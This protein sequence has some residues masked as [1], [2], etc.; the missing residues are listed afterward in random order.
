MPPTGVNAKVKDPEYCNWLKVGLALYYLKDG[1]GS[2]IQDE[3]DAM[4]QSLLQKLYNASTVPAQLCSSCNAKDVKQNRKTYAWE[5]K[6]RCPISL[7]DT[8]LTELLALCTNPTSSKLYCENCAVTAWPKSPWECA[9]FYMPRG[10]AVHN[11]GPAQSDSQALLTLMASCKHF[12]SKL[13]PGGIQLT[14]TVS[15]IRNTVMHSGDMRLSDN[16]RTRYITDIIK[17]LEDPSHLKSL[18][19]CKKAVAEINK[20]NTDS[21]E[22]FFNTD[23][24]L[25]MMALRACAEGCRQELGV[26]RV[27]TEKTVESLKEE[28]KNL[29][30]KIKDKVGDIDT[31]C[32]K[33]GARV[34]KLTSGLKNVKGQ[35]RTQSAMVKKTDKLLKR[36][37]L[38]GLCQQKKKV[39][40]LEKEVKFIQERDSL[41]SA[42]TASQVSLMN[43]ESDVRDIQ[44]LLL[45]AYKGVQIISVNAVL[46]NAVYWKDIEDFYTDI[47]IEQEAE[48]ESTQRK[49]NEQQLKKTVTSFKQIFKKCDSNMTRIVL[50]APAGQGKSTFCRKLVHTWCSVQKKRLN[51]P[52]DDG[53]SDWSETTGLKHED[54]ML[55]FDVLLYICLRDISDEETLMDVVY[56]QFPLD[57][58]E[59][60]VSH[61]ETLIGQAENNKVLL[62][63]DGLDEM[64]NSVSFIGQILQRKLY[65]SLTVLATTR[66]WKI[67]ELKLIRSAHI[68][69]FLDL[70]GF[71][72]DNSMLFAKKMFDNYYKDESAMAQFE[73]DILKNDVIRSLIHVPLLL[74]F[75]VQVWYDRKSFPQTIQELY[76]QMFD[77]IVNR[78]IEVNERIGK[79]QG[80]Q[81]QKIQFLP[82]GYPKES[83]TFNAN[84]KLSKLSILKHFGADF[85]AALCEVANHFLIKACGESA[86]V[87]DEEVLLELLG[88]EGTS[89]LQTAL[90]LGILAKSESRGTF[91]KKICLTFLHKTVQEFLA[92][93]SICCRENTCNIFLGSLHTVSDVLQNEQIIKFAAGISTSQCQKIFETIYEVCDKHILEEYK[94]HDLSRLYIDCIKEARNE[95]LTLKFY[96]LYVKCENIW[97]ELLSALKNT[98]TT[99]IH[100]SYLYLQSCIL[101][102]AELDFFEFQCLTIIHLKSTTVKGKLLLSKCT[103]LKCLDLKNCTFDDDV[104]DLSESPSL[105]ALSLNFVETNGKLLLSKCTHL[106]YLILKYCTFDDDILDLSVY[107]C[108][109]VLILKRVTT[110]GKLLLSKCTHLKCF[111]IYICTL[112]AVV[113]DFSDSI[114]LK[115][116]S[117]DNVTMRGKLLLPKCNHLR[118]LMINT[119]TLYAVVLDLSESICLENLSLDNVTMKSKL[120]LSKC[121]HLKYLNLKNCTVD[122][123][124]LDLSGSICLEYISLENVTMNGK[125]SLSKCT[126]LEYLNLASCILELNVFDLLECTCLDSFLCDRVTLTGRGVLKCSLL[127]ELMLVN[128]NLGEFTLYIS[129]C[130]TEQFLQLRK[131]SMENSDLEYVLENLNNYIKITLDNVTMSKEC[132]E[133]F[134]N[135]LSHCEGLVR[136]SIK[137]VDLCDVVLKLENMQYV[138]LDSVTMSNECK[139]VFCK[140]LSQLTILRKLS[141]RNLDLGDA[142]L[143]FD[144]E[145]YL[146]KLNLYNVTMSKECTE[147]LCKSLSKC[148]KLEKLSIKNVDLYDARL[149]LE[150]LVRISIKNVDLCDVVLKLDNLQYVILDSVTMS[151]ECKEVFCKSL[152]QVTKFKKLSIKN[153]DLCDALLIVKNAY[154]FCEL[155][156]ERVTMSNECKE[157]FYKSISRCTKLQRLSIINMDLCDAQLIL[158]SM[159]DVCEVNLDNVTMSKDHKEFFCK[160]LSQC[161]ELK[162]LSIKNV[163]LC[164]AL[165]SLDSVNYLNELNLDNLKMSKE[166]KE[167][168]C[169]SLSH[170]EGLE[171]LSI[172]NMDLCDGLNELFNMKRLKY[173]TVEGVQMGTF[174]KVLMCKC[175]C[176]CTQLKE[177]TLKNL[178]LG[179]ELLNMNNLGMLRSLTVD[180]VT[181]CKDGYL[182]ICSSISMCKQLSLK[183]L[184]LGDAILSLDNLEEF[185]LEIIKPVFSKVDLYWCMFIG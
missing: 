109:E 12:H 139:E 131:T 153:V 121:T 35:V 112:D 5:F 94:M 77:V 40:K 168:F 72:F 140:S 177:L 84:P 66:S 57:E 76:L 82:K 123:Y 38:P 134:Y 114:C 37:A 162:R 166:C 157:V 125:L 60:H 50:Q 9:K 161:K 147:V 14:H 15:V 22:V 138:I 99:R 65:P 41:A 16:D 92:A 47:V 150:G 32:Q 56:S 42:A 13:S 173:I 163:D 58:T 43:V 36:K 133:V 78:Y 143:S 79:D 110:K 178:D 164:N 129:G 100:L 169:K 87:F 108:L 7:C 151:K 184:D 61:I 127:K 182:M 63:M 159:Y 93:I 19:D 141:I 160:S 1:L 44:L 80:K 97:K 154:Y 91:K 179:D 158:D 103:H 18:D 120:L 98:L 27:E 81:D 86:L 71:S 152:S 176:Q 11:I 107:V 183:N 17:L 118:Y 128:C 113:L 30:K 96:C 33:M 175:L 136:I 54:E 59:S 23:M 4:H 171:T 29:Q 102:Y 181:M 149:S 26:Q 180:N 135:S 165:V 174:G 132:K 148:K 75:I 73:E 185:E 126:H 2:F 45:S 130:S 137:N 116:L 104:L 20:I 55:R 53:I 85:L 24:E 89:V 3:V 122:D 74:L 48:E 67:G 46:D 10:Q 6:N 25:E 117:L 101:N 8:W 172:K 111:K 167:V 146:L 124:A 144:N 31:K 155:T 156:L 83:T 105:E 49:K 62:I 69:L 119:C 28:I 70:Q 88:K 39:K 106:K 142:L 34:N 52:I 64:D 145:I 68:D 170:F 90:E 21:L 115:N 95:T 51:I